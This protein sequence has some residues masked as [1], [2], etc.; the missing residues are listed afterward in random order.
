MAKKPSL[1]PSNQ[2]RGFRQISSFGINQDNQLQQIDIPRGPHIESLIVR[3]AG[4]ANITT[5][6]NTVRNNAAY[7][8]LRSAGWQI[9]SNVTLDSVSGMQLAQHYITNRNLPLRVDPAGFGVSSQPFEATFVFDRAIQDMVRPKDSYLQT[10]FGMSNNQIRLQFGAISD[11]FTGAGVA[12]PVGVTASVSVIDYQEAQA[13]DGS[14]PMPGWYAKRNGSITVIAGAGNGQQIK[15]ST[16]N[17]LRY[18]SLRCLDPVTQEPNLALLSR[19]KLSR[20]GD[21]RVDMSVLDLLRM[22]QKNYGSAL[23]TGQVVI[24][25]AY[26]GGVNGVRYSEFWPIPA[27]ADTFL[28]IDTTAACIIE[29]TTLEGVDVG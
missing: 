8:Y 22:N 19:V 11:M 9:N 12:A 4:N 20:A 15:V 3:V 23:M 24:D 7:R 10:D 2:I 17:R 5:A 29:A 25:L 13:D 16:G 26:M 28:Y 6:F 27:S 21:T 1:I 14:T 18:L